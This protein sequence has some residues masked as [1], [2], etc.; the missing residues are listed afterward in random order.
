[1]P[2]RA[3]RIAILTSA[4]GPHHNAYAD[5]VD[6]AGAGYARDQG[7]S[8]DRAMI[9]GWN[10][11]KGACRMIAVRVFDRRANRAWPIIGA[12]AAIAVASLPQSV[13]VAADEPA[14]VVRMRDMP[15]SFDPREVTIK[16]GDT[17]KWENTGNSVHHATDDHEMVIKGDDVKSPPGTQAFDSGFM[18]PG[19]SFTHTFT[20]P[21]IYKYV[22]VAH[23]ASGM[24]GEVVVKAR[25]GS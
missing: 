6:H 5:A 3:T 12:I 19:E 10:Q 16:V 22:C 17:V 9:G 7:I 11:M 2:Y 20:T 21:G 13:T 24:I 23:E 1:M 15:P 8:Q 4:V 25:S 18:R 14:I